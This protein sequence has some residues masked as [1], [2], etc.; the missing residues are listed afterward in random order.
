MGR[1]YF[2]SLSLSL[3]LSACFAES[4]HPHMFIVFQ[5]LI[6]MA[7]DFSRNAYNQLILFF[8]LPSRLPAWEGLY[9]NYDV[10]WNQI[11]SLCRNI[12]RTIFDHLSYG[13]QQH[14][15]SS[16]DGKTE[17][18]QFDISLEICGRADDTF[19]F[20]F[21]LCEKLVMC[22]RCKRNRMPTADRRS[23]PIIIIIFCCALFSPI[24]RLSH[25]TAALHTWTR[26]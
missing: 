1:T 8:V 7:L 3:S 21:G 9:A 15:C 26:T 10:W 20:D 22:E 23:A 18:V 25:R 5:R 16:V 11:V 24:S 14:L 17:S 19:F 13:V 2:S 4:S 12:S 6:K